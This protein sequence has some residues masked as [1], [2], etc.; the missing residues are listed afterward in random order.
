MRCVVFAYHDV[1]YVCLQELLAAGADV[2]AVLTHDDDPGEEIW[3]RSVRQLAESRGIPVFA[4]TNVNTPEWIA[5]VHAWAP[6]FVFSF[7]YRK[8]L[9][10]ELL[11]IPLCG[12]LNLH[13]SLLPK[14]RGRCPVNWVLVH[15]ERETGVTLHYMEVKPDRGDIVAQRA[16]AIDDDDTALTLFRKLTAAAAELMRTTYPLLRDGRAPR[17]PQD[18]RLASYFGGRGP[19]DGKIVWSND[20]D[21][22]RNLIRAVAHPYPGAFGLWR[23][24]K[25][26]V[27][28]ARRADAPANDAAPGRVL[29]VGPTATDG[30]VVQTGAGGLRIIRAQM[31]GDVERPASECA[32]RHGITQGAMLT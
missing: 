29:S 10:A 15:G 30:I 1:G 27:W 2:T 20:A 17:V 26:L 25:L 6:D 13:G 14:Y 9:G 23:G 5:R 24:R 19:D 7:Y 16:V 8:L 4:P 28:D 22:I 31:D 32:E 11:A 21:T 12:A 3:F 18:Q